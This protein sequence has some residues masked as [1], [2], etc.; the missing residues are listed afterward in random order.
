VNTSMYDA[1]QGATSGAQIDAN[2]ATGTNTWHGDVYGTFANNDLNAS[3]FFFNQEYQLTAQDRYRLL[4]TVNGEPLPSA[5]DCRRT[6]GGPV[7]KN[8]VFFLSDTSIGPTG[9]R[10]REFRS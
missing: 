7:L 1:Q 10:V 6:A 2:T 3:P 8:K 4:S 9:T 5:L